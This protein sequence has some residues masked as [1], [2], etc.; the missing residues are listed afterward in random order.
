[1][2]AVDRE[3]RDR[4]VNEIDRY[5][6]EEIS[7]F[8]FNDAIFEIKDRTADQTVRNAVDFL[9]LFYDDCKDHHVV[10]DRTSWNCLQRIRFLLKTDANL[11][12]S[13]KRIWS[14][15]QLIALFALALFG[16]VAWQMGWGEHLMIVAIPFGLVSIGLSAWRN[17]LLRAAHY[18]DPAI[19]PF[20][21]VS[22]LLWIAHDMRDFRK[23]R[24]PDHLASRCIR[25]KLGDF[26][27]WLQL[28][29][30]WLLFSP[31]VLLRQLFPV[32]VP[33][34]QVVPAGQGRAN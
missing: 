27:L 8:E 13:D 12:C 20:A 1:M 17:R 24:F 28:Y 29:S 9:W 7:A 10:A 3:N 30:H 18:F 21:S 31:M 22:Q 4:L 23:E 5:L 32:E 25:S 19:Y 6:H 11:M 26:G 2:M 16:W 14:A 34:R 15:T 33:I